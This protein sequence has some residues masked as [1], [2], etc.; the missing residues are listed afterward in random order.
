MYDMRDVQFDIDGRLYR[1]APHRA[2]ERIHLPDLKPSYPWPCRRASKCSNW[3]VWGPNVLLIAYDWLSGDTILVQEGGG[4]RTFKGIVHD[5]RQEQI[6]VSFHPDFPGA[7]RSYNVRFQLNRTPLRRMHQAIMATIRSS[8]RLLFPELGDEGLESPIEVT[9]SQL[10][11]FNTSIGTNAPQLAAVES[12]L[13]LRPGCA[14][15]VLFGP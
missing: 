13:Q 1:Y 8:R 4:G 15:F 6:R 12:I 5:I 11:L 14:P 9:G 7:S 10:R 2:L 3:Y